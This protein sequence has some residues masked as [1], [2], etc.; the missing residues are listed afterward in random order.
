M[1]CWQDYKSPEDLVGQNALLKQLTKALVER[2]RQAVFR[3]TLIEN[4]LSLVANIAFQAFSVKVLRM[5]E[6]AA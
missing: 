2:A 3:S 4:H 6:Q 5:V 1:P